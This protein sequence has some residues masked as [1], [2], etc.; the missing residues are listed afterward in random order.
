MAA[1]REI[2][3]A[4]CGRA[5]L[6]GESAFDVDQDLVADV[7]YGPILYRLLN[8]HGEL[9]ETFAFGLADVVVAA[10]RQREAGAARRAA[11]A[12]E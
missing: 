10:L 9:D 4:I 2:V 5:Q 1:H 3:R 8:G 12:A 6:R 7:V 11:E